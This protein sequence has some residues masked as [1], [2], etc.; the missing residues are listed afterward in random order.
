MRKRSDPFI[1]DTEQVQPGGDIRALLEEREQAALLHDLIESSL[2]GIVTADMSGRI[3]LFNKGAARIL[4]YSQKEPLF[5]L[6]VRQL[7]QFR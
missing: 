3:R 5:G 2:D 7:Y 6:D 1:N 4:G